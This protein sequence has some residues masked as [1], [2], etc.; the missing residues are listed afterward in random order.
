M[1]KL[2]YPSLKDIWWALIV[3]NWTLLFLLNLE[4]YFFLFYFFFNF[5]FIVFCFNVYEFIIDLLN[6]EVFL[7]QYMMQNILWLKTKCMKS[8]NGMYVVLMLWRPYFILF[9]LFLLILFYNFL[10]F[11]LFLYSNMIIFIS[12]TLLIHLVSSCSASFLQCKMG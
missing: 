10:R 3:H 5:L 1:L 11:Q 8:I 12:T 2:L 9:Y 4:Y 7:Q 6:E